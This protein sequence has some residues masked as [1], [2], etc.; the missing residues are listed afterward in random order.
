MRTCLNMKENFKNNWDDYKTK[1]IYGKRWKYDGPTTRV[2]YNFKSKDHTGKEKLVA[3][4]TWNS[5]QT[6]SLKC[7][8]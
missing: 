1:K 5:F 8:Y 7:N 4:V 6:K 2:E 3:P